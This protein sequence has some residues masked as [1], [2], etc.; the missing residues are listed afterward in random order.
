MNLAARLAG[1]IADLG[2]A[3]PPETQARL[4]QYL[5]L[6]QKWNRVHNLTALREPEIM[7]VRH[8]L[9]SLSILPHVSG[10]WVADVGSGAGLPGIPLALARPEWHVV[11]IESVHKKAAFLQQARIELKLKNVEVAAERVEHYHP[12]TAFDSVV[13]RAFS[14]LAD[15]VRQAGHLCAGGDGGGRLLA[16]KGLYPHE[17]LAQL[18]AQFV[19]ENIL[20]IAVPGLG[21]ERHLVIVKRA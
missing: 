6:I 4:L 18:P 8:V 11:L 17:E 13:S 3:V 21:S 12:A 20:P 1:G 5:A 19:V 9:D 14:D 16:M 10:P 2:E 15:F 7:L